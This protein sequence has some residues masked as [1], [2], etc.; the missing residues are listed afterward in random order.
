MWID[1]I[2]AMSCAACGGMCGWV[3][4]A[5]GPPGAVGRRGKQDLESEDGV[6][7]IDFDFE[8]DYVNA[9]LL[10]RVAKS[11][12]QHAETMA[13]NLDVH[14]R[15]VDSIG[16]RIKRVDKTT[17]QWVDDM[18]K[19]V[20]HANETMRRQLNTAQEQIYQQT[21]QLASAEHR[22][23]TDALTFIP[24]RRAFDDYIAQRHSIGPWTS[25]QNPHAGVLAILDVDRFKTFNDQHGHLAGDEVLRI[26][27][28]LLHRHLQKYGIVA[29]FGGE[30]F[31]IIL[32]DHPLDSAGTIIEQVRR[33]ITNQVIEL[34]GQSLHVTASVGIA[35]LGP[36]DSIQRWIEMADEALYESKAAGRDCMFA[37]TAE[38]VYR[39][40]KPGDQSDESLTKIDLASR[41][42][43][44]LESTP[45]EVMDVVEAEVQ[46]ADEDV[47]SWLSN[48]P[49]RDAVHATFDEVRETSVEAEI[50]LVLLGRS[51]AMSDQQV[52][53]LVEVIRSNLRDADELGCMDDGTLM[54]LLPGVGEVAAESRGKEIS[55]SV[56]TSEIFDT[57]DLQIGIGSSERGQ[58]FEELLEITLT[59][60]TDN[61]NTA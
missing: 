32:N 8:V 17:P 50:S 22:A 45:V 60:L 20:I 23:Q 29:R 13:A 49:D 3:S 19:E 12:Q 27:A 10:T 53:L 54:V 34:E 16:H 26:V 14:Q 42:P 46:V 15:K 11:L 24:N 2:L 48:L 37:M 44:K 33:E 56:V 31:A 9:R 43:S 38:G 41:K 35:M 1:I 59:R 61:S 39:V 25:H 4:H 28:R 47:V 40:T 55:N 57:A 6:E 51:K 58:S 18:V 21:L 5:M 7:E 52:K 36:G 30:E